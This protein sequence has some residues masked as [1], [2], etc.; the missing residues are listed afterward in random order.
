MASAM[1]RKARRWAV[2]IAMPGHGER[3]ISLIACR[4][5]PRG[6]TYHRSTTSWAI[7]IRAESEQRNVFID[8]SLS[9]VG[10]AFL[11]P[12]GQVLRILPEFQSRSILD[13]TRGQR[14]VARLMRTLR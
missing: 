7:A 2:V 12:V 14:R 6:W 8:A 3:S 4:K 5:V 9:G 10:V 11:R 1:R 13:A